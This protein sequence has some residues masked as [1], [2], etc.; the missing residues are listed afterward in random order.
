MFKAEKR[1]NV[2][3]INEDKYAQWM[4]RNA[5]FQFRN[6]GPRENP[7][8]FLELSTQKKKTSH[9]LPSQFSAEVLGLSKLQMLAYFYDLLK[10][11]LRETAWALAA[12]DTDS[13]IIRIAGQKIEDCIRPELQQEFEQEKIKY[14]VPS[15]DCDP[16]LKAFHSKTPLLLKIE[17][18][19]HMI[20]SLQAKTYI[21]VNL[22]GSMKSAHKGFRDNDENRKLVQLRSFMTALFQRDP[23]HSNDTQA[24]VRGIRCG[25]GGY[26]F[27]YHQHRKSFSSISPKFWYCPC[28]TCYFVRE[29]AGDP[30]NFAQVYPFPCTGNTFE[31]SWQGVI[32]LLKQSPNYDL[33]A[34]QI[35][36]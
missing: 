31:E 3:F 23:N 15:G 17:A 7:D 19:A 13:F 9:T 28:G 22:D 5:C 34:E 10:K 2:H 35:G 36:L 14:F 20:C 33:L 24:I 4:R 6:V 26:L 27:T 29:I 1:K 12:T 30:Q 18:E 8:C 21:M 11:Y 16:E 25:P 32:S